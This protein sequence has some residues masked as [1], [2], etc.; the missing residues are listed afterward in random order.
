MSDT[1]DVKRTDRC[2][3]FE[4]EDSA[5]D[6]RPLAVTPKHEISHKRVAMAA[7][8]EDLP[9]WSS[10]CATS[11]TQRA[12]DDAGNRLPEHPD[13][14]GPV[15]MVTSGLAVPAIDDPSHR[16]TMTDDDAREIHESVYELVLRVTNAEADEHPY[17]HGTIT[18]LKAGRQQAILR[19]GELVKQTDDAVHYVRAAVEHIRTLAKE[20]ATLGY[21]LGGMPAA[22]AARSAHETLPADHHG[23]VGSF[24]DQLTSLNAA[25][26]AA[27]AQLEQEA[28]RLIV[29]NESRAHEPDSLGKAIA[30]LRFQAARLVC[31]DRS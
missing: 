28:R 7:G 2:K 5:G 8:E 4:C 1:N 31:I 25:L 22:L 20:R 16:I 15:G 23:A 6:M 26:S 27:A 13:S 30:T 9:I 24:Y 3:P 11:A 17:Y 18:A 12:D 19:Y 21:S 14:T 29:D 10:P